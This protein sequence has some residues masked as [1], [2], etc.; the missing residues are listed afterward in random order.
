MSETNQP[1]RQLRVLRSLFRTLH[2]SLG[3]QR[4]K[5]LDPAQ[6]GHELSAK[7][8]ATDSSGLRSI[9]D[10]HL[11]A[12]LQSLSSRSTDAKKPRRNRK[13]YS[14]SALLALL[15][16][17]SVRIQV[18]ETELEIARGDSTDVP[19]LT[20]EWEE[21]VPKAAPPTDK[22]GIADGLLE[23]AAAKAAQ[24]TSL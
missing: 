21:P 16:E 13:H 1:P 17:A 10:E 3:E 20:D 24:K 8:Q 12:E 15:E 22:K 18:L 6:S 4:G 11:L 19:L 14:R 7:L 9:T 23:R 2:P 5:R